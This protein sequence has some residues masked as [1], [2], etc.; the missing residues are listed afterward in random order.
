[1]QDTNA[2]LQPRIV[3]QGPLVIAGLRETHVGS[4]AGIPAQ[5]VRFA[6]HVG[7]IPGE[8]KGAAYGVCLETCPGGD[9]SF[10]YLAGVAV[11]DASRIP[12][13]LDPV[14]LP[15]GRYA[16]FDH[17]GHVSTLPQTIEGIWKR[18]LPTARE[19][20]DGGVAFFERYGEAFD[21]V[22]GRGGI[23]VWVPLTA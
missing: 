10:D 20:P 3:E 11:S 4:N 8:I 13:G 9:G 2:L 17:D 7:T 23:E 19:V 15:A 14:T 1:M 16:V 21:P 6:S 12:E 18:W 22:S 5:W